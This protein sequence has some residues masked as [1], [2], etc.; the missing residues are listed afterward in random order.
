MRRG[1]YAGGVLAPSLVLPPSVAGVTPPWHTIFEILAFAGGF[2]LFLA[3]RRRQGD[4]IAEPARI[5]IT[6]AA[7]IGA[8][9][10]ARALG[11]LERPELFALARAGELRELLLAKTIVGG[12]LGGLVAV[13]WI[14]R[15]LKV[16]RSSGDLLVAPLLL[17]MALGRIGCFLSGVH[18]GTHGSPTT[19]WTALDLGDGIG[20]HPTALYELVFLLGLGALLLAV[21]RRVTLADGGRFKLFLAAYLAFRLGIEALK[22]R[23]ELLA[24]LSAIQL[25]CL[26][27]LVYYRRLFYAPRRELLAR[28]AD[29]A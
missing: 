25:A 28:S 1:G 8:L 18:D 10:G 5:V 16:R 17:G 26:G 19:A 12:L 23:A 24:G 22:P 9:L 4:T 21:E 3:L 11:V 14:K 6:I 29:D 27:G 13:E 15:R 2:R 20:R 7:A